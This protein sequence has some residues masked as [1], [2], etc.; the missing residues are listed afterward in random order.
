MWETAQ[1]RQEAER[2]QSFLPKEKWRKRVRF[3][4]TN[5]FHIL[6]ERFSH[7]RSG[8]RI[9]WSDESD[10]Y[11]MS[12]KRLRFQQRDSQVEAWHRR[13]AGWTG[14]VL[15]QGQ[16]EDSARRIARRIE[17]ELRQIQP[18]SFKGRV[19]WCAIQGAVGKF[20]K[21]LS[22][23]K[24][25]H[26]K[27]IKILISLGCLWNTRRPH[28]TKTW[29]FKFHVCSKKQR[30]TWMI[31]RDSFAEADP[32]RHRWHRTLRPCAKQTGNVCAAPSSCD[33]KTPR[34]KSNAG[35]GRTSK[36]RWVCLWSCFI[37]CVCCAAV[38][39][40]LLLVLA[41]ITEFDV[42]LAFVLAWAFVPSLPCRVYWVVETLVFEF[43][44]ESSVHF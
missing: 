44:S 10:W 32:G 24:N 38:L 4:D 21:G 22:F 15:Q 6:K 23:V 5:G 11:Q 36:M 25:V 18:S 37:C 12:N 20:L 2:W 33:N 40:R 19:S 9:F 7:K 39:S 31:W 35:G 30:R 41:T 17:E 29:P 28:Q 16:I 43:C 42:A 1:C 34:A 3:F 27:S 8:L 13:A 14:R 26:T